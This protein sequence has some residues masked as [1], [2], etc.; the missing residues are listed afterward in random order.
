MPAAE[1]VP[2][3]GNAAVAALAVTAL[4]PA[5]PVAAQGG[6]DFSANSFAGNESGEANI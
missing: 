3:P 5:P 1:N 4:V 2:A 6:N